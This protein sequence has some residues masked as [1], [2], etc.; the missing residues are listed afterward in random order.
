MLSKEELSDEELRDDLIEKLIEDDFK[1]IESDLDAPKGKSNFLHTILIEG[2]C[3]YIFKS[4]AELQEEFS[5][6]DCVEYYEAEARI[7]KILDAIF[8]GQSNG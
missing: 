7:D 2:F 1:K 4:T 5:G 3:G 6:R 8:G